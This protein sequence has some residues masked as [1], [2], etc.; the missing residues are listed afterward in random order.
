VRVLTYTAKN[1]A[2]KRDSLIP[3]LCLRAS[4]DIDASR[5][6][7][8]K[9]KQDEIDQLQAKKARD[10]DGRNVAS[11]V[12]LVVSVDAMTQS[13]SS[14]RSDSARVQYLLE[15]VAAASLPPT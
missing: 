1:K 2:S 5:K 11:E 4:N 6:L 10:A 8:V 9:K 3:A 7:K 13:L 12:E 14:K 15:Q